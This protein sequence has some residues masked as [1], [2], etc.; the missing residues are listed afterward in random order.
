MAQSD[1]CRTYAN[2]SQEKRLLEYGGCPCTQGESIRASFE[3]AFGKIG[4]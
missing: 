2:I 3:H 4:S 1:S